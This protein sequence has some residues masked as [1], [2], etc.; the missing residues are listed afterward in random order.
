M[1]PQVH[2]ASTA[3][4]D[5]N[6]KIEVRRLR[7]HAWTEVEFG[8]SVLSHLGILLLE[9]QSHTHRQQR[10]G[11]TS[12]ASPNSTP[13]P[14]QRRRNLFCIPRL[15]GGRRQPFYLPGRSSSV[16]KSIVPGR[17]DTV[18]PLSP[19]PNT[20]NKKVRFASRTWTMRNSFKQNPQ[21][22]AHVAGKSILKNVTPNK[23]TSPCTKSAEKV[24][25]KMSTPPPPPL[26]VLVR[27]QQMAKPK[28]DYKSK[29]S[30]PQQMLVMNDKNNVS[31]K[32]NLKTQEKAPEKKTVP[33][34]PPLHVLVCNQ[35]E[36]QKSCRKNQERQENSYETLLLEMQKHRKRSHNLALSAQDFEEAII[37]QLT[38]PV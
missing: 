30:L 9:I 23:S 6:V 17:S 11:I 18:A 8:V 22:P 2:E 28:Q 34:L 35:S 10:K 7:N 13:H 37:P 36:K 19:L 21:Q 24:S 31:K 1:D 38:Q 29:S 33:S 27:D 16:E 14:W 26:H 3:M 12:M 25:K 20:T 15:F 32:E 5:K 4:D